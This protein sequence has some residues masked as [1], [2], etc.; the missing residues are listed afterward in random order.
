MTFSTRGEPMG[1]MHNFDLLHTLPSV[2]APDLPSGL[3]AERRAGKDRRSA[4][5]G[6]PGKHE[7]RTAL[8]AR[9]PQVVELEM[10]A[11]D[12]AAFNDAPTLTKPNPGR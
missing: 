9:K 11:S 8:E 6:P 4:E 3:A 5:T 10:S 12:W 7:R 1:R 2:I